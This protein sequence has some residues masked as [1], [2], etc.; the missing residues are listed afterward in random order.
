MTIQC[1]V[2]SCNKCYI[3]QAVNYHN[4]VGITMSEVCKICTFSLDG[5]E[6]VITIKQQRGPDTLNRYAKIKNKDWAGAVKKYDRFHDRCRKQF[7]NIA[8]LK[9]T[10]EVPVANCSR[11]SPVKT[12]LSSGDGFGNQFD[13]SVCCLFCCEEVCERIIES[14]RQVIKPLKKVCRNDYGDH[15]ISFVQSKYLFDTTI[16][17]ELNGRV[18]SWACEVRGRVETISCLRSYDAVY[19]RKCYRLFYMRKPK[20]TKDAGAKRSCYQVLAAMI[21]NRK[22]S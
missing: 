19:H 4:L 13:Y 9:K 1:F 8:N 2:Q 5:T 18:D 6:E 12:R 20:P 17:R 16:R 11:S 15:S 10:P 7:T 14:G 21:L 3:L 22:H